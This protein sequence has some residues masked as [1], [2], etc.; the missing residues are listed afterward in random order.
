MH[1]PG[2]APAPAPRACG[3]LLAACLARP[4]L[5]A[6]ARTGSLMGMHSSLALPPDRRSGFAVL[7]N[8]DGSAM[9]AMPSEAPTRPAEPALDMMHS[10]A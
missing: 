7:S 10:A 3:L 1:G 6:A 9:R 5:A 2:A 4:A 8:G